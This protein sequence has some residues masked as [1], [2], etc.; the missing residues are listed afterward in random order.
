[1]SAQWSVA[2]RRLHELFVLVPSSSLLGLNSLELH[3]LAWRWIKQREREWLSIFIEGKLSSLPLAHSLF[4]S[5]V[6]IR[7]WRE[8]SLRKECVSYLSLALNR[9]R[10]LSLVFLSRWKEPER[11]VIFREVH[12]RNHQRWRSNAPM[13]SITYSFNVVCLSLLFFSF[14]TNDIVNPRCAASKERLL[15]HYFTRR[16]SA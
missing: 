9:R 12:G 1:M 4:L 16:A 8:H 2:T 6:I 3:S 11:K 10:L 5:L 15:T 14:S 13:K 7:C